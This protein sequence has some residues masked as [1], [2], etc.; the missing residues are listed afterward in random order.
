MCMQNPVAYNYNTQEEYTLD[1][2]VGQK[3]LL[4]YANG[5]E[6]VFF[7]GQFDDE[8][9]YVGECTANIYENGSLKLITSA[10]Y[11]H[12]EMVSFVKL[13]PTKTKQGVDVWAIMDCVVE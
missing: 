7:C 13:F 1:Q 6:D 12:G 11:L 5:D 9:Y 2:L 10:N 4:S 8:G 3:V